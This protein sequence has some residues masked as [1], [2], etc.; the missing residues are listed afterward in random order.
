VTNLIRPTSRAL[1]SPIFLQT[2][3]IFHASG[4]DIPFPVESTLI[5]SIVSYRIVPVRR[6]DL[7]DSSYTSRQPSYSIFVSNFVAMARAV[8]RGRICLT[9][10]NSPTPK[11]PHGRKYLGDIS[12]TSWVIAYFISDFVA[13]VTRVGCPKFWLTSF[14]S[15]TPKTTCYT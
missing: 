1:F 11:T 6:K 9:S 12:Y 13:M 14:N 10:F 4:L 5:S 15:L 3:S 8:G 2:S 7:G